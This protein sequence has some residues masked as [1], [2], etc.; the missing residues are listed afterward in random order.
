MITGVIDIIM[1]DDDVVVLTVDVT[2]Q[3][4]EP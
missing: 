2:E 4:I 3:A 1:P